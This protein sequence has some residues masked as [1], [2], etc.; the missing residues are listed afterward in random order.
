MDEVEEK[1]RQEEMASLKVAP[2]S[3]EKGRKKKGAPQAD[4]FPS[5]TARRIAPEIGAD[6][7]KK[8]E[9]ATRLKDRKLKGLTGVSH[10]YMFVS[11]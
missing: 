9:A 4:T 1:E 7:K 10:F 2:S 3:K 8:A 6:I 11:V 5:P